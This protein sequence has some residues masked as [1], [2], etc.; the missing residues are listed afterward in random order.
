VTMDKWGNPQAVWDER[1][2]EQEPVYGTKPNGYVEKQA[3]RLKAGGKVLVPADGYGRNG[4]WLAR[5]GFDVHTVDL[6]PVGVERSQK[7]AKAAGLT[8]KI[9]QADLAKWNW[10]VGE[11]DGV[12]AIFLHLPPEERA[13]VHGAMARALKPGGLLIFEAFSRGQLEFRTGGP[14]DA[15]L[16]YTAELLR[17]DFAPAEVLEL[18]EVTQYMEEGTKHSGMSAVVHGVFR[19]V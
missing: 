13:K 3:A 18:E 4:Q 1:F 16:L 2:R 9:E 10:P 7:A 17:E 8:M 19:A 5:Q 12:V 6:S 11:F 15:N 14:K